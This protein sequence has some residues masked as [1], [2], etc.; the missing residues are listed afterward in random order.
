[1]RTVLLIDDDPYFRDI[2]TRLLSSF[3]TVEAA[4][5]GE[6]GLL[7]CAS[8]PPDL[9]MLDLCLPGVTGYGVMARLAADPR[10]AGVPVLA[11]SAGRIDRPGRAA[12]AARGVR[13]ILDKISPPRSFLEAALGATAHAPPGR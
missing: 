7:R 1:M 2:L 4:V 13:G 3:F 5:D 11:F 10:T 6:T 8:H 9:V 12:L